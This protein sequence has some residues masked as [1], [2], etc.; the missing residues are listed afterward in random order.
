MVRLKS[1]KNP[2]KN[3][4]KAPKK[5]RETP[6]KAPN[7][8]KKQKRKTP[9]T[10]MVEEWSNELTGVGP[11]IALGS[12]EQKTSRED[13]AKME[14]HNINPPSKN[15]KQKR[16]KSPSRLHSSARREAD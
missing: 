7:S 15:K 4:K 8:P 5:A 6:K 10:T 13:L 14:I 9:A 1:L 12:Q 2:L 11:S 16:Q 3:P